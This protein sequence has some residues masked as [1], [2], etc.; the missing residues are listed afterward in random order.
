M[1][2][3]KTAE[4]LRIMQEYEAAVDYSLLQFIQDVKS[5]KLT[6]TA[7]FALGQIDKIHADVLCELL[8]VDVTDF[9]IHVYGS[10][11]KH[12]LKRHGENGIHDKSMADTK[13]IARLPWVLLNFDNAKVGGTVLRKHNSDGTDAS[14]VVIEKRINGHYYIGEVVPNNKK[15]ELTIAS[16]YKN[17]SLQ[18][19]VW[20][21]PLSRTSETR[22]ATTSDNLI[23]LPR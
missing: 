2:N 7:R 4:Q 3:E 5:G 9:N 1:N 19:G 22:L 23:I 20:I 12:I 14:L 21:S 15:K 10:E 11:I 13:D 18:E 8:C 6:D 17:R 16:A